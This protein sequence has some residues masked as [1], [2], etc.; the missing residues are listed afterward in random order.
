[1]KTEI[2]QCWIDGMTAWEPRE[3]LDMKLVFSNV[4]ETNLRPDAV[5]VSQTSLMRG[6]AS[7]MQT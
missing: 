6:K 1:M 7:D 3:D 4:A 2:M 5:S